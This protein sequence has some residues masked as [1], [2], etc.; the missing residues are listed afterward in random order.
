MFNERLWKVAK[1]ISVFCI[2]PALLIGC[3]KPDGEPKMV[4]IPAGE[5]QMGSDHRYAEDDEKPVHT[6]HVDAFYMDI[7][8]VT[9]ADYKKFV[10]ANPQWQKGHAEFPHS[11]GS[12]EPYLG[13]WD[14]NDY[15]SGKGNHPVNV[16]WYAA[17]AYAAWAGKRLPTEAEWEKAARGG[18]KDQLY[19]W[20]SSIDYSKA[21]YERNPSTVSVGSYPA[22]KYGLYDMAGNVEEWCLDMYDRDFYKDSPGRNPIAGVDSITNLINNFTDVKSPRVLRSGGWVF[23]AQY[24]R[25]S[26]RY[27]LPP[28]TSSGSTG[29]RCVKPVT[30]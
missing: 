29:F 17:M 18:L 11:E 20:G 2:G 16:N 8:E 4:L 26:D 19:P 21:N 7:Y 22:N 5:F 12:Q 30:P 13:D 15:P 14:G 3:G 9:N 28:I 24:V 10:D 6:V 23:G 25:V 1:F 27:M